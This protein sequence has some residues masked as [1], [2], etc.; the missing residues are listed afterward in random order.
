MKDEGAILN[1]PVRAHRN[2]DMT[3]SAWKRILICLSLGPLLLFA[4]A[5]GSTVWAMT[6]YSY[7]DDQ[8]NMVSTDSLDTIPDKYRPRVKSHERPDPVTSRPSFL[9][10]AQR[11]VHN[12]VKDW[13]W[14]MPSFRVDGLTPQQSRI[15]TYAGGIAI[16]LIGVMLL[17]KSQF[18]RLLGFCLL[19]VL[20]IG[21]PVFLYIS[22]GGTLDVMKSKAVKAGQAQQ[23]RL[24]QVSP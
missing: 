20:G 17:A 4:P 11:T 19:I 3:Y 22:D 23:D 13:G 15:L 12:T 14:K 5:G 21:T 10:A 18:V 9:Q 6:I 24:Q 1:T 7:I 2:E 16:L 8:G